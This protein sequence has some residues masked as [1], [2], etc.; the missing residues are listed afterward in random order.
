MG[1]ERLERLDMVGTGLGDMVVG[2]NGSMYGVCENIYP[3]TSGV[4]WC[5][6]VDSSF[7]HKSIYH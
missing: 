3:D 1:R 7:V 4:P 2:R 6:L 5:L